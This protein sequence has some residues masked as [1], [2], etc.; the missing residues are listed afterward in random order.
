MIDFKTAQVAALWFAIYH[1]RKAYQARREA[2]DT[3]TPRAKWERGASEEAIARFYVLEA[4][5]EVRQA[6]ALL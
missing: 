3:L 2:P 5:F 6:K 1:L 4:P